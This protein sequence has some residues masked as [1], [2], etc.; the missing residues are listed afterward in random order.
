MSAKRSRTAAGSRASSRLIASP[1]PVPP[2]TGREAHHRPHRVQRLGRGHE[3]AG[4]LAGQVAEH[5]LLG[6]EVLVEGGPGAP[7]R[8]RDPADA[9]AVVADLG[10]D[11]ERS[12]EDALLG[13]PANLVSYPLQRMAQARLVRGSD[14]RLL[15]TLWRSFGPALGSGLYAQYFGIA[16]FAL[17]SLAV[18]LWLWADLPHRL[19]GASFA[20]LELVTISQIAARLWMKAASAR[21]V[22][23]QPEKGMPTM[24]LALAAVAAQAAL[25]SPQ[26]K[27]GDST[28]L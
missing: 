16:V 28:R 4:D 22:A 19:M 9:A 25:D 8:L 27:S 12:V 21:W 26:P 7:G 15:R 2:V 1:R 13:P 18:G 5:V 17:V 23:L 6:R 3:L 11:P 20:V 24:D 10:E 14:R